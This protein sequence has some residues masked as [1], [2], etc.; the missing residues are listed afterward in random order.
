[1]YQTKQEA[2]QGSQR[3]D[4]NFSGCKEYKQQEGGTPG[5]SQSPIPHFNETI[6]KKKKAQATIFHNAA[7]I[8]LRYLP[9]TNVTYS[10]IMTP[11]CLGVWHMQGRLVLQYA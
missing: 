4:T 7:C 9:N 8:E 6:D 5:Q 10:C 11:V 1:V 3:Y 2:W